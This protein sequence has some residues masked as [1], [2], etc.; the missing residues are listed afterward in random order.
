MKLK[1]VY[2][3][4]LAIIIFSSFSMV[5]GDATSTADS[6]ASA[7]QDELRAKIQEKTQQLQEINTQLKE[8]TKNLAD[9]Q[10][11]R[12]TL[13]RQVTIYQST[14]NQLTLNIKDDTVSI[15]KLGLEVDSLNYDL[16][17]IQAS[18]EDKKG[19]INQL[20]VEIQKND[21]ENGNLL[22][23]FLKN[24]TL[25]ASI[26]ETQ[27]LASLRDQ[28]HTD[29]RHLSELGDLY[30]SKIEEKSEKISD[31]ELHKSN[32]SA[33]KSIIAN[34]KEEQQTVLAQ[35]KNKEAAYQ[36]QLKE[37]Q[38]LQDKIE[39]EIELADMELRQN[40]NPSLLPQSGPNVLLNP[41]PKA[42]MSQGYGSTS[43]AI[44]TY[45]GKWHNGIDLA[46]PV[47]T[48]VFSA[49]DGVVINVANQDRLCPRAAYGKLIVVK[50][51]NGLTTLYGHLSLQVVSIGQKVS[52][53][54]LIGYVGKTGWATGPHTHFVVFATQTI[55]PARP[56]YPEGTKPSSCGPMPV[57][58]D[59]NPLLYVS[60]KK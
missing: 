16:K 5:Y 52:R 26:L 31:I 42:I 41:V 1:K 9:T 60:V 30:N 37:I 4:G 24:K 33:R 21:Y 58:G 59:I 50:H 7:P 17:D 55:T 3:A 38:A 34:Q 32:L 25:A 15:E 2:L 6:A 23:L 39:A 53:G 22:T 56:G 57:G 20:L 19:A 12:Q 45:R 8:T 46:A 28:L 54:Q 27:S 51:D 49:E 47:G 10:S 48:E 36:K 43:F 29:V 18:I 13:Q 35:T 40:I 44:Q 14:I 11:Q